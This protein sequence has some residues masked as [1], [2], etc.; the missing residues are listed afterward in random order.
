MTRRAATIIV[1]LAIAGCGGKGETGDATTDGAFDTPDATDVT[2][3]RDA[4]GE[5]DAQADVTPD[6]PGDPAGDDGGPVDR[7]CDGSHG[8]TWYVRPDGGDD[9]ECNGLHDA[10]YPGSGTGQDC[11]FAH[12]FFALAPTG[13]PAMSGGDRLVIADGEYRMGLGGDGDVGCEPD[14]PYECA[15]ASV[16]S[17]P[18]ADR[19]TCILGAGWESGCASMPVLWGVER[20]HTVVDLTGSDNVHVRCLEITDHEGC[21]E[22]H[23]GAIAC[24]R[25]GYPFGNWAPVG[26]TA[27]DSSGVLLA[28][29]DIHGMANRGILAGRL[30]DWTLERVRIAGNGWAGFDGD[31]EG[32]D[33]NTG[34]ITFD[35]VTI[36]YNGCGETFPGGEPTGCWGQSAGGYGDGLGT[37]STGGDWVFRGCD[38]SHNTSDGLDLLYHD[39]GGTIT[40]DSTRAEGNAGNQVK[41]F[42]ETHIVNTVMV[43]NCGYFDEKS[44]THDVDPCRAMGNALSLVF[45]E[46]DTITM[47]N[48]TLYSEGD[49]LM[50]VGSGCGATASIVSRN[51]VFIGAT[52]FLDP[53]DTTCFFYSECAAA[54]LDQDYGSIDGTKHDG[55]CPFGPHDLC[56]PPQVTGPLAGDA[57]GL[58]LLSTS[59]AVDSG[60]GVG[61]MGL[62]PDSDIHGTERPQ[63][64]G[65]DRGA[66]ETTGG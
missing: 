25:M 30:T 66:Y 2:G 34:T 10:A 11:A 48:S 43:G 41:T 49:C 61:E 51:N 39:Q 9:T 21:V 13:T 24:N 28:D 26:V 47:V 14:W 52:E 3:D 23:S 58:A 22:F 42:G 6:V 5:P 53:F 45:G 56:S 1:A 63:G 37:G 12:P 65:V 20:S 44:F 18:S 19:P 55:D 8:T 46:A 36:E 4:D 33:S 62:V 27:T 7:A 50:I 59:P 54:V 16:P 64:D 17:G 38:I 32:D 60:L 57:F 35:H 31:V 40:V 15:M 29:L